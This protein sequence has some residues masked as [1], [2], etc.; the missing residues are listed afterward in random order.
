MNRSLPHL[1]LLLLVVLSSFAWV[2]DDGPLCSDGTVS[3]TLQLG[4][5]PSDASNTALDAL[6]RWN[7]YMKRVQLAGVSGT[8]GPGT[9]GNGVNEVFFASTVYGKDFDTGVLAI[10][11]TRYTETTRLESDVIVNTAKTWS[12]YT[13]PWQGNPGDLRRVLA[14]E[15]GHVL[16]LAHPDQ[17]GQTLQALMNAY[18]S[19]VESPANDDQTGVATLYGAPDSM[20][21]ANIFI[22]APELFLIEGDSFSLL[23]RYI[24][25]LDCSFIWIKDGTDLPGPNSALFSLDNGAASDSGNYQVR[26]T[27]LAGS[28]TSAPVKV[29]FSPMPAPVIE[30]IA[31]INEIQGNN[32]SRY[33]T[34]YSHVPAQLQWYKDGVAIPGATRNELVF[35][36]LDLP[37]AGTYTLIATNKGGSTTSNSMKVTVIPATLPSFLIPLS[38]TSTYEHGSVRFIPNYIG[39]YPLTFAWYKDGVL[40]PNEQNAYLSRDNVAPSDAGTYKLVISNIAG[41]TASDDITLTVTPTPVPSVTLPPSVTPTAGTDT[42]LWASLSIQVPDLSYQ[43]YKNGLPISG[44]TS[45]VHQLTNLGASDSG[46]YVIVVTSPRGSFTSNP[47]TIQ[48]LPATPPTAWTAK[49]RVGDLVYFAYTSPARLETYDLASATWKPSIPLAAAPTALCEGAGR[50]YFACDRTLYSLD[51]ASQAPTLLGSALEHKTLKLCYLN[52]RLFAFQRD[53]GSFQ[54][55]T[56]FV[57]PTDSTVYAAQ[58][59][60]TN[61]ELGTTLVS[62]PALNR[63]FSIIIDMTPVVATATSFN[64]DF[65]LI[66]CKHFPDS[67][68]YPIGKKLVPNQDGTRIASELGAVFSTS[69]LSYAG[70]LGVSIDLAFADDGSCVTIRNTGLRLFD[71]QLRPA[72]SI[73]LAECGAALYLKAGKAYV[74]SYPAAGAQAKVQA[75]P[76]QAVP[77]AA[78]ASVNPVGLA[79]TPDFIDTDAAGNVL[80]LSRLKRQVF[81]WDPV[82]RKFASIHFPLREAPTSIVVSHTLNRLYLGY[83]TGMVRQFD[84]A[85]PGAPESFFAQVSQNAR[86][87]GEAGSTILV[88]DPSMGSGS[89]YC[90]DKDGTRLSTKSSKDASPFYLWVPAKG[91]Y[92]SN[93]RGMEWTALQPGGIIGESPIH[94]WINADVQH[95]WPTPDGSSL[96]TNLG[97]FLNLETLTES[98]HLPLSALTDAA[99]FKGKLYTVRD[100][101]DG[102][103][104]ERW[105]GAAYALDA[106]AAVPGRPLR[107]LSLPSGRL[108]LVLMRANKLF[109]AQLDE[110]LAMLSIDNTG[111]LSTLSNLS[112]RAEAGT[113]DNV[114]TPSFVIEGSQPKRILV[115]AIG[116]TLKSFGLSNPIPDPRMTAFDS[117]QSPVASNEDW[118]LA[119]NLSDLTDTSNRLGAFALNAGSKDAAMLLSLPP[120]GYTVQVSDSRS[121]IGPAMAEVYDADPD[122]GG[123]R[124]SNL[125]LRGKVGSGDSTMIVGFVISGDSQRTLLIRGIGPGLAKFG[126]SGTVADPVLKLFIQGNDTPIQTND[127][128]GGSA[129]IAEAAG[130]TGAF[131]LDANSKDA[132]MLVTLNPGAYT[133]HLVSA[134]GS[135]GVGLLE[136]YLMPE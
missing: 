42:T 66:S 17:H 126:V 28:T 98:A 101:F 104:L 111:P 16:G 86:G 124:L 32:A 110:N 59:E 117:R 69:D 12:V 78:P 120:G 52:G 10:T 7:P 127:N 131:D 55:R 2:R 4:A 72:G 40:L 61:W 123:S 41:S 105:G 24:S 8:E 11:Y 136:L 95:C 20:K 115:R 54:P 9:K 46:E 97:S 81:R 51:P 80:L 114:L 39:S 53:D 119:A 116:P 112:T 50:L 121:T 56:V 38:S 85:N 29:H 130:K 102:C 15:F 48:V 64:P 68:G 93:N 107:L 33:V 70:D 19:S 134:D 14:H 44:A 75:I 89:D 49:T 129:Q 122:T 108:L 5:G 43:W 37:N 45:Y 25:V 13:G 26:A 135:T 109:F 79:F 3:L 99:S 76:L 77:E 57:S 65:S 22:D 67:S 74:F 47:C 31:D 23:A 87:L 92:Y 128:W 133:A 94:A 6:A 71:A 1:V 34:V 27:N 125:A 88:N 58:P 35:H 100:S 36:P 103:T 83:D 113:G 62:I 96:L 60:L 132:C 106:S 63:V 118:G 73:P 30:P 84:L 90:F 21:P 18:V 82:A 91:R